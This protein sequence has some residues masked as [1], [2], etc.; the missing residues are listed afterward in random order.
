[1]MMNAAGLWLTL[2]YFNMTHRCG[3]HAAALI[4]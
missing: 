1:M 2:P 3:A 4:V